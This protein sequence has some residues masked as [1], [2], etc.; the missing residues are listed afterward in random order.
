MTDSSWRAPAAVTG[1]PVYDSAARSSPFVEEL[2]A[3]VKYRDLI[4]QLVSR[5][6]KTRYKR[7]VLGVAWTMLSPLLTMLVLTLVF[8]TLFRYPSRDYALYVLS[9]LL[10]WNFFAQSTLAA[11]NDL[12]WSGG[13]LGRIYVP[14]TVFAVSA[15]GT[16]MVNLL[17]ALVPYTLIAL[18]LG[19]APRPAVLAL[20]L[21]VLFAAMFSVGVGLAF[22]AAAVYFTDV[23][24]T[25]EVLLTAWMYLTPVIYPMELLP[26]T[27]QGVLR[28]NPMYYLVE[29]FRSILYE[30]QIPSGR[31]LGIGFA[32]SVTALVLGWWVF[33]RKAREYAYRV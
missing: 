19:R 16:A 7:S 9:A 27:V 1:T 11:M 29:S 12:I 13:L 14:K 4:V 26:P 6:I 2:L 33:T 28:F 30:G 20:P 22:S 5:S 17:L 21:P 18:A 23:L 31:T 3:L 8:S 32:V 25:Y 24:P 15:V 10:V